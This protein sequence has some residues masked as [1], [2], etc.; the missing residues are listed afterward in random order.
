MGKS[1]LKETSTDRGFCSRSLKLATLAPRVMMLSTFGNPE[2][3]PANLRHRGKR[4]LNHDLYYRG[5][6]DVLLT[7][8]F[9]SILQWLVWP[10]HSVALLGHVSA[11]TLQPNSLQL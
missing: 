2:I 9:S 3:G 5:S 7:L 4:V 11:E 8:V 10:T 6:P 1:K